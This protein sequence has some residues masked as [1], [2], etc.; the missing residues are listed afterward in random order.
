MKLKSIT[1]TNFMQSSKNLE[2]QLNPSVN[3]LVGTNS[4]GKTLLLKTIQSLL[5]FDKDELNLKNFNFNDIKYF[6]APNGCNIS[7]VDDQSEQL[8]N[9]D[10][11]N[12]TSSILNLS[13]PINPS[14]HNP[15]SYFSLD[16]MFD[17]LLH[18]RISHIVNNLTDEL[19]EKVVNVFQYIFNDTVLKDNLLFKNGDIYYH[20]HK[21]QNIKNFKYLSS[22]ELNLLTLLLYVAYT[23]HNSTKILLLD[24]PEIGIDLLVQTKIMQQFLQLS[25]NTQFIIITHSAHIFNDYCGQTCDI[26]ELL[27]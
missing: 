26:S 9:T 25:P 20:N 17:G 1:I 7:I 13:Q 16:D 5:P 2:W 4:S 22:G 27:K 24:L 19:K 10:Y 8:D 14:E 6:F 11:K 21:I 12:T 15:I 23:E 3:F 18:N